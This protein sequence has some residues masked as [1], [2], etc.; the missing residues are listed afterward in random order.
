M[1]SQASPVQARSKSAFCD[2]TRIGKY[3]TCKARL[4]PVRF[5]LT[6][7]QVLP[8]FW[9]QLHVRCSNLRVAENPL[10]CWLG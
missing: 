10:F 2:P 6:K 8:T 5:Q 9:L 1:I 4:L 3:M 7:M